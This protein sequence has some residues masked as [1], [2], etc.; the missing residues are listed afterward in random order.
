M[1]LLPEDVLNG[2]D[3]VKKQKVCDNVVIYIFLNFI[4]LPQDILLFIQIIGR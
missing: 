3:F 2:L 4:C 1:S